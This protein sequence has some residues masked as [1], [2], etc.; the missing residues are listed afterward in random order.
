MKC[1]VCGTK[2]TLKERLANK[3]RCKRCQQPF[4]F[5]PSN[6]GKIQITDSLF[7]KFIDHVSD[8]K[9]FYFTRNQLLYLINK[10]LGQ[11]GKRLQKLG[12]FIGVAVAVGLGVIIWFSSK[13][14][15]AVYAVLAV[16]SIGLWLVKA[17]QL[18]AQSLVVPSSQLEGWIR[19]WQDLN[20][21]IG[22]MLP[23]P[24]PEPDQVPVREELRDYSFDRLV[25]CDRPEIAQMLIANN[26]HFENN[27]AVL[28][29]NGYPQS[30]FT[31]VMEMLRQNPD[32]KVYALHDATPI[33]LSLVYH[34]Q[35]SPT[36]FCTSQV[37]IYDL[38]LLPR[39]IFKN[40]QI[41]LRKSPESAA[42]AKQL[43]A[44]V[45]AKLSP[46]EIAWLESGHYVELDVVS[47]RKLLQVVSQGII[48]SQ[49]MLPQ[50]GSVGIIDSDGTAWTLTTGV[51]VLLADD[52]FG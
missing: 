41:F 27:C 2:N 34:L 49:N 52:N 36:W 14:L 1:V 22:K 32:L 46:Q 21:T 4:A 47:P 29:F 23:P 13:Q 6:M 50:D 11:Q 28:S 37:A 25:V 39:Q 44:P 51:G 17:K 16:I 33:G 24:S 31:T 20:R 18:K 12:Q 5:E 38:G 43:P 10:R 8:N 35:T 9:T 7:D 19:R 30:I 3:G 40:S 26:F 15:F 48:R 45:K 42:E